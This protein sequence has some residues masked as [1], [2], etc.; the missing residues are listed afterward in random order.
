MK[1][2]NIPS[3]EERESL[4]S[5]QQ[6]VIDLWF[7]FDGTRF[8]IES[9]LNFREIG[10]RLRITADE[11]RTFY[12]DAMVFLERNRAHLSLP[13]TVDEYEHAVEDAGCA[14]VLEREIDT[15]RVLSD[16]GSRESS[17]DRPTPWWKTGNLN[18]IEP[19]KH[20]SVIQVGSPRIPATSPT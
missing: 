4:E 18:K 5:T 11:A 20:S 6:Q 19:P 1:R 10:E 9:G 14:E 3:L 16:E 17:H 13:R 2:R 8:I 12:E 7:G 15:H